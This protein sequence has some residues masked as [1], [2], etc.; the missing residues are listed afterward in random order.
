MKNSSTSSEY[1]LPITLANVSGV[2]VFNS[3]W[4]PLIRGNKWDY[5]KKRQWPL[6]G[7]IS[8]EF[9]RYD[10]NEKKK[11]SYALWVIAIQTVKTHSRS[12]QYTL[13]KKL[14]ITTTLLHKNK[15]QML[16]SGCS[17]F[18][19]QSRKKYWNE[20]VG[21]IG[22]R[23]KKGRQVGW[24]GQPVNYSLGFFHIT[25][26]LFSRTKHKVS[27]FSNPTYLFKIYLSHFVPA[28]RIQFG[29]LKFN[30]LHRNVP[31]SYFV[32]LK[33]FSISTVH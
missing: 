28:Q 2:I 14:Y 18:L 31:Y 1:S 27:P 9:I 25:F 32:C 21:K 10:E 12:F 29:F 26:R 20:K 11:T 17:V 24:A 5:K 33:L 8:H 22:L 30:L 15:K 3:L 7:G 13:R 6:S 4:Q 16:N 23:P 19:C